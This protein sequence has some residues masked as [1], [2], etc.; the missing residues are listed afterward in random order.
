MLDFLDHARKKSLRM[1]ASFERVTDPRLL[2]GG[3]VLLYSTIYSVKM[4]HF[5][6]N[7]AHPEKEPCILRQDYQKMSCMTGMGDQN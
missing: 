5:E 4:G 1:I 2:P 7:G 6:R 3:C